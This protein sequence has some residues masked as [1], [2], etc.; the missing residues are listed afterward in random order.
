M[1]FGR[2][3]KIQGFRLPPRCPMGFDQECPLG[4]SFFASSDPGDGGGGPWRAR[5]GKHQRKSRDLT[6]RPLVRLVTAASVLRLDC[7]PGNSCICSIVLR[8]SPAWYHDDTGIFRICAASLISGVAC[9]GPRNSGL[10]KLHRDGV[11]R[12]N[13]RIS[14]PSIRFAICEGPLGPT[15]TTAPRSYCFRV[16]RE[17]GSPLGIVKLTSCTS[18]T[19]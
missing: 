9:T 1:R 4:H 18:P 16:R 17:T 6:T 11:M 5:R 14:V 2:R 15:T 19:L 8:V 13:G 12:R 10:L 7:P 3:Q